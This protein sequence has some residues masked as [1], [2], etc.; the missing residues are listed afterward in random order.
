MPHEQEQ[1][2]STLHHPHLPEYRVLSPTKEWFRKQAERTEKTEYLNEAR[3]KNVVTRCV[4]HTAKIGN[5][6]VQRS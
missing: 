1:Y 6:F 3:R 4:L 2:Q 5:V